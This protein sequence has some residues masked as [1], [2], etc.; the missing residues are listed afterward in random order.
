MNPL[1]QFK[2]MRLLSLLIPLSLV[3]V[4][5]VQATLQSG[6][7]TEFIVGSATA[8]I[9]VGDLDVFAKWDIDPAVAT[10]FWKLR[11]DSMG[12]TDLYVVQN[13]FAPVTAGAPGGTT[14]WH[15]H[16]GPSLI[17]VIEGTITAYEAGDCTPHVYTVGMSFIDI[18]AGDVH[19]LRNE[20][21]V[22]AVTVAVQ[23]IPHGFPRKL[24]RG[25][26]CPGIN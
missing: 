10:H 4:A 1:T 3:A 22:P 17:T 12:A 16:P 18:G 21:T 13:T 26:G 8:G 25:Q 7:V 9:N 20:G 23:L 6:V 14:G 24:D 2:T 19:L 15:T 11:I 5:P